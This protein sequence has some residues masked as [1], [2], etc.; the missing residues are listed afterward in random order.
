MS[1]RAV[2]SF[3]ILRSGTHGHMMRSPAVALVGALPCLCLLL[4]KAV[5]LG[6]VTPAQSFIIPAPNALHHHHH[7][8]PSSSQEHPHRQRTRSPTRN[9]HDTN[10]SSERRS[11]RRW[12]PAR[13]GATKL[14]MTR[15]SPG[16]GELSGG[17]VGRAVA[18]GWI[19]TL[20]CVAAF[21]ASPDTVLVGK[22]RGLLPTSLRPPLA[23]AL[24]EEQVSQA[25]N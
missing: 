19:A 21:F 6:F 24:S 3:V 1:C 4:G 18:R 12:P 14:S 20:L 7:H 15:P 2:G 8:H 10:S 11:A 9:Q 23:S 25:I 17:M 5:V 22:P 13:L 16:G